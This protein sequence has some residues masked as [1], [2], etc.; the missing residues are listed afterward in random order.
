MS[1][2]ISLTVRAARNNALLTL[3]DAGGAGAPAYTEFRTGTRPS[4]TDVGASGT[5][6][7]TAPWA[8]PAGQ[9]QAATGLLALSIAS[10]VLV[11]A[12][13][14]P[15]WAR[16]YNGAGVVLFDGDCTPPTGSGDFLI[17]G[18]TGDGSTTQVYAG[19]VILISSGTLG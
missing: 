13:G 4:G 6:I 17:T 8:Y 19:G 7:A 11:T 1:I 2:T 12:D 9:I 5:L 18:A 14:A 15:T 3:L 16:T 10:Q